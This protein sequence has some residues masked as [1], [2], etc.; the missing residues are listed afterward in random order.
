MCEKRL[1]GEEETRPGVTQG[2]SKLQGPSRRDEESFPRL[3][4]QEG[5]TASMTENASGSGLGQERG[6][7]NR[8]WEGSCVLGMSVAQVSAGQRGAV[9]R[10]GQ[11][12]WTWQAPVRALSPIS[13]VISGKSLPSLGLSELLI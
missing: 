12:R 7:L 5:N 4:R 8:K 10:S 13:C 6:V 11:W 9:D 1:A 2:T 3:W